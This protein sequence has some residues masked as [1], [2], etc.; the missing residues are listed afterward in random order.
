VPTLVAGTAGDL[1]HRRRLG[2]GSSVHD[3][4]VAKRILSNEAASLLAAVN[5][6][7]LPSTRRPVTA[8]ARFPSPQREAEP[9]V[10]VATK[11][12]RT[13]V[14]QAALWL[15]GSVVN[16]ARPRLSLAVLRNPSG[17]SVVSQ[18]GRI[19]DFIVVAI[20]QAQATLRAADG[21]HCTLTTFA[22]PATR[23][24]ALPVVQPTPV[25]EAVSKPP[26]G[27]PVFSRDELMSGVRAV[28]DREYV[29]TRQLLLKA[30][31]NPGGA[32]GGAWFRDAQRNGHSVGMEVRAVRDGTALDRMGIRTGDV[33]HGINGISLDTPQGLLSALR[34]AR[35]SHTITLSVEREGQVRDLRYRIE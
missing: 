4:P 29:V 17:A 10:Q 7:P 14:C 1:R 31:S 6:L 2:S 15:V 12:P 33:A 11:S 28:S 32:A 22:A 26:P 18:G 3:G 9:F 13:P 19:D 20:G 35:E 24:P 8:S 27:K 25:A 21:S 34:S 30:L 5:T 23:A 16:E